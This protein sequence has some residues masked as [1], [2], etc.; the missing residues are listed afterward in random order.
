M[1]TEADNVTRISAFDHRELLDL[2]D[3]L[4]QGI[5]DFDVQEV[6]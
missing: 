6:K 4:E 3:Q 5:P 1:T 2:W